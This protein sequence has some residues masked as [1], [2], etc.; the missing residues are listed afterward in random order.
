MSN[1]AGQAYGLTILSP[2][3]AGVDP[4]G[5][6]HVEAVRRALAELPLG[7]GSPFTRVSATHLT[8]LV[9]IDDVPFEWVPA[10]EDHLRSAYLLFTSNFD[11]ALDPYLE[12]MRLTMADAIDRIWGRCVAFPGTQD[13]AAFRDYMHKC[14]VETTFFFGA[15]PEYPTEK[16]RRALDASRRLADFVVS[17]Q[18]SNDDQLLQDFRRFAKELERAPTPAPA[19]I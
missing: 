13:A 11:G 16:V 14:Q 7:P 2:I 10:K 9:V 8:R 12:A 17:H 18:Q 5:V 19:T 15:Y 6:S 4:S 1:Q 3:R